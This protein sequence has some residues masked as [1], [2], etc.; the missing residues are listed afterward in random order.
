MAPIRS[1]V[2]FFLDSVY[3]KMLDWQKCMQRSAT[4]MTQLDRWV[5]ALFL[6]QRIWYWKRGDAP[7]R[8]RSSYLPAVCHSQQ[9][10]RGISVASVR[11]RLL[12][13]LR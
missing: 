12:Q 4:L 13:C 9:R 10:H 3:I 6:G 1:V 11:I 5:Y 2:L 7:G 8:R